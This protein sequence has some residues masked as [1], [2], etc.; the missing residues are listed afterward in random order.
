M[1]EELSLKRKT[2]VGLFLP[3]EPLCY[4]LSLPEPIDLCLAPHYVLQLVALMCGSVFLSFLNRSR[5][6]NPD[7]KSVV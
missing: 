3:W 7:R 6:W 4:S 5:Q 1:E 2:V